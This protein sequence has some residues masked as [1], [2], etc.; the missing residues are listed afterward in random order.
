MGLFLADGQQPHLEMES[1]VSSSYEDQSVL[2]NIILRGPQACL[3]RG[4]LALLGCFLAKRNA[5][6]AAGQQV[7]LS[8]EA[9]FKHAI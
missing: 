2:Q 4:I 9:I 7:G 8:L 5:A 1:A 3:L 6:A